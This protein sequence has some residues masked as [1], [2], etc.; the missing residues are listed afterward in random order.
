MDQ[1]EFFLELLRYAAYGTP[2]PHSQNLT[3]T[4]AWN[5]HLAAMG[6][7]MWSMA[8]EFG[9]NHARQEDAQ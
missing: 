4:A 2:A 1:K 6:E 3:E 5:R 7:R 9:A 8:V